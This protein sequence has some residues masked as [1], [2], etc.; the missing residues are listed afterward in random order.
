MPRASGCRRPGAFEDEVVRP[1]CESWVWV[2][3]HQFPRSC[4]AWWLGGA[5]FG[6]EHGELHG[7]MPD[8]VEA[9]EAAA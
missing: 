2:C 3:H 9:V 8:E 5:G 1:P 4:R 7:G 6:G